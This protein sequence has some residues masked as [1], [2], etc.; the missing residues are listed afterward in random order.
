[1]TEGFALH[2]IIV[3]DTGKPADYRFIEMNPA[4]ERMT[5]MQA[6]EVVGKTMT[7]VMP[8]MESFWIETYGK[9]AL[10]GEPTTFSRL[11]PRYDRWFEIFVYS[12]R[13]GYFATILTDITQRKHSEEQLRETRDYL[14]SLIN[15]ANAPI[16]VWNPE[17]EI[18]RFNHAFERLTGLSSAEVIGQKLD[19]LFPADSIEASLASIRKTA[20]GK[21]LEEVEIPILHRNGQVRTVLWNSAAIYASDGKTMIATIAHGQDITERKRVD[22]AKD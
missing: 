21:K 4:Y 17:F 5:G 20:A 15:Y 7:E 1:M 19:I 8:G 10:S 2:E 12:P 22:Q 9:V 6:A 16:I 13:R 3:D 14:D 18:T 11:S